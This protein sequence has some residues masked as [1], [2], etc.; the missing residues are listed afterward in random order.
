VTRA[1]TLGDILRGKLIFR[2]IGVTMN[3]EL[4]DENDGSE[5]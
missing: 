1:T 2:G 5:R 3:G 4:N